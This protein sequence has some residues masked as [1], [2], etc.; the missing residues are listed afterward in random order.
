MAT[1]R[2]ERAECRCVDETN[3]RI[4]W[5]DT[6][7]PGRVCVCL[8]P[9]D[10]VSATDQF[11]RY[12]ILQEMELPGAGDDR[13]NEVS[14]ECDLAVLIEK[15]LNGGFSDPEKE[16]TNWL[17]A[18]QHCSRRIGEEL[19]KLQGEEGSPPGL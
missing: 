8:S 3:H 1:S 17:L 13:I 19:L 5:L 15:M 11:S 4:F 10:A 18:L 12:G 6:E 2:H 16:M 9:D 7:N 14:F